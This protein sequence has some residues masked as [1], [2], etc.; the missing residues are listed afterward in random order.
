MT[1][2]KPGRTYRLSDVMSLATISAPSTR[3]KQPRRSIQVAFPGE[4]G[5]HEKR[6]RRP[7]FRRT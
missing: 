6:S 4:A 5:A 3:S 7:A 2:M 1:P